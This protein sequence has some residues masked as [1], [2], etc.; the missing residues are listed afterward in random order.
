MRGEYAQHQ[1]QA[2][3]VVISNAFFVAELRAIRS[4]MEGSI[5]G[6]E[7]PSI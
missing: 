7:P 1:R 2:G 4:Y 6:L 5:N 3:N